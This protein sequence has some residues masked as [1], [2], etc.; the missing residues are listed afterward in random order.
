MDKDTTKPFGELYVG[1]DGQPHFICH[2]QDTD[3]EAT[4]LVLIGFRDLLQAQIDHEQ[5][6]PYWKAGWRACIDHIIRPDS[7]C[8]VC[9]VEE[10][11]KDLA[12]FRSCAKTGKYP[13]PGDEPSPLW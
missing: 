12:F 5:E 10:V 11:Q 8:P 13:N 2:T 6:C 3:F 4:K 7:P 1:D 9:K